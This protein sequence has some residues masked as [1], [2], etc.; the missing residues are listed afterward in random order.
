LYIF[1][2]IKF[3][4]QYSKLL[5]IGI[6]DVFGSVEFSHSKLKLNNELLYTVG[7][8]STGVVDTGAKFATSINDTSDTADQICRRCRY[9]G[10]KFGIS[11]VDTGGAPCLQIFRK[12]LKKFGKTLKLFSRGRWFMKKPEA[13]NLLTLSLKEVYNKKT[14]CDKKR[15]VRIF[16]LCMYI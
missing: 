10:G 16:S 15:L 14:S 2:H 7:K 13:K 11:V 5:S 1:V 4:I 6:R 9:T 8:C 12:I 3:T